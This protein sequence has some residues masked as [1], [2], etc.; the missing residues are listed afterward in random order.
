MGIK[1]KAFI[2]GIYGNGLVAFA[3]CCTSENN[4]SLVDALT[5]IC[6]RAKQQEVPPPVIVWVDNCCMNRD[7]IQSTYNKN[8]YT[9]EWAT[10]MGFKLDKLNDGFPVVALDTKH[11]VNRILEECNVKSSLYSDFSKDVHAS[12]TETKRVL[13]RNNKSYEIHDRLRSSDFILKKLNDI[14]ETAKKNDK[15]LLSKQNGYVTLFKSGFD[16]VY[17]N[18]QRHVQYCVTDYPTNETLSIEDEEKLWYVELKD[19]EFIY[20]RGT[21][22]NES[23]HKRLN[24]II[25]EKC[26][27]PLAKSIIA[28]YSFN[29]ILRRQFTSDMAGATDCFSYDGWKS[30]N[31]IMSSLADLIQP[32]LIIDVSSS[33][34]LLKAS[35]NN[36]HTRNYGFQYKSTNRSKDYDR[37]LKDKNRD[38][39]R[40]VTNDVR[41]K[42]D[43]I[44]DNIQSK[45]ARIDNKSNNNKERNRFDG[46]DDSIILDIVQQ[47]K[48]SDRINWNTVKKDYVLATKNNL[49]TK[50]QLKSLHQAANNRRNNKCPKPRRYIASNNNSNSNINSNDGDKSS[51]AT[52]N[53][54]GSN[55]SNNSNDDNSSDDSDNSNNNNN[56]NS[57]SNSNNSGSN[58]GSSS[59]G[60]GNNSKNQIS[61]SEPPSNKKNFT[62]DENELLCSLVQINYI[63]KNSKI[64]W[65]TLALL[66]NQQALKLVNE[67]DNKKVLYKRAR[68]SLAQRYR[69]IKKK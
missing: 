47:N 21:N 10:K 22:K 63:S 69:D 42:R 11:L 51:S 6:Q 4:K 40:N 24:Y 44:I 37:S 27:E 46:N 18:Q 20:R 17:S 33:V 68:E 34:P 38:H 39:S 14:V 50:E 56:N 5:M 65:P 8:G 57:N 62:L 55:G 41:R 67:A 3:R 35:T 28:A 1:D 7:T 36:F 30:V 45:K 52:N 48:I 19:G 12:F 23:M 29:Y 54:N 53:D 26:G 59:I 60:G 61:L 49:I 58:S 16:N 15:A 32:N 25:P 13:S 9:R 43:S 64:R 66:Y 31:D 2:T